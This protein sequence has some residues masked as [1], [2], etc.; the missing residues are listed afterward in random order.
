M[1]ETGVIFS[2]GIEA[3]FLDFN[4]GTRATISLAEKQGR[5]VFIRI[6]LNSRSPAMITLKEA[7]LVAEEFIHSS[8]EARRLGGISYGALFKEILT[9]SWEVDYADRGEKCEL[10]IHRSESDACEDML[11]RMIEQL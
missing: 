5:L 2:D 7:R 9:T 3:D 10:L 8:F 11:H 1:G 6:W 4:S